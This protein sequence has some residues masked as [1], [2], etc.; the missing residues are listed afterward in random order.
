MFSNTEVIVAQ[1]VMT[2]YIVASLSL[3]VISQRPI[4]RSFQ[5]TN[6]HG[7]SFRSKS[8]SKISSARWFLRLL[9]IM[10]P[11]LNIDFIH[12]VLEAI[13]YLVF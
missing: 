8:F 5:F 10:A 12:A 13:N 4:Y 11:V 6:I 3:S 2:Q 7:L 9:K 1:I